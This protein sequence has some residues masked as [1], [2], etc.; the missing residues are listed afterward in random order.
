MVGIGCAHF[1]AGRYRDAAH[2][3]ER[4]LIEHPSAAWIHRTLCP[5]HVL[6]GAESDEVTVT[7]VHVPDDFVFV[8]AAD[9]V[10]DPVEVT[11]YV[12]LQLA[13]TSTYLGVVSNAPDAEVFAYEYRDAL[14]MPVLA[15][16]TSRTAAP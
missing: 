7:D 6:A 2:W 10:L 16:P 12:W 11:G 1:K 8:A 15:A 3:Q 13:L 14:S 4:G 9:A 5:A